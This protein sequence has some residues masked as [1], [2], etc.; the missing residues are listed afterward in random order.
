MSNVTVIKIGGAVLDSD[1]A[2]LWSGVAKYRGEGSVIIVHGGGPQSTAL[3]RRLDHEPSIIHGRRVTTDLDLEILKMAV[4]GKINV[5]LVSSASSAGL[6]AVGITGISGKTVRV[7]RR[8][9]WTVEG[10]LIDFGHV[11]DVLAIRTEILAA[12]LSAGSLPIVAC[13]GIDDDSA[14]YNVNADTVAAEIAGAFAARQLIMVTESGGIRSESGD[15]VQTLKGVDGLRGISD[16][17]IADGMIVKVH[18]A[19]RALG[20][21]VE[22]VRITD[23]EGVANPN[24]GTSILVEND[25]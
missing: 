8:P 22:E 2:A 9:P 6:P 15:P 3:A 14:V 13:M 16:G 10:K 5:D 23:P 4:G 21:G 19:I 17:W 18:T 25:E 20:H 11:G 12:L 1:L 24:S 7:I